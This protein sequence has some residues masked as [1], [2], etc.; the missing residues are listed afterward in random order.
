MERETW[1]EYVSRVTAGCSRSDVAEAAQ[2]NVSAISRWLTSVSPPRAEKAVS[3]ARGLGQN[4]IEALVA[5]GYLNPDEVDGAVQIVRGRSEL[6]D[7]ELIDELK[8]RLTLRQSDS[9]VAGVD[10]F[11]KSARGWISREAPAKDA[12]VRRGEDIG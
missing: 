9:V 6:S 11:K 4:P 3:F 12:R 8:E 1:P 5:A 7:D 2:I 10:K